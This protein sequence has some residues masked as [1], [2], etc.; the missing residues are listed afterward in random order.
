LDV[1][2]WLQALG[3]ERYA[4]AFRDAQITLEALAELTDADLRELGLPLG[5]R[6]VVLKAIR[7]LAGSPPS[8]AAKAE[9][10]K[11]GPEVI[12]IPSRAE[13]RQLTVMFVDLVGSTALAGRL[14]PEEMAELLHGYREAVA[15]EVRRFAGHVAKLMGDGVLAYFGWPRAH[16]D[17]A[18]RAVLAGL[19]VV[20][21]VAE[22]RAPSAEALAARVGIATGLVVVGELVGEAEARERSVVGD[23][24]NLAARLQ[25]MAE[26]GTVMVAE[27]TRRLLGEA[28]AYAEGG[29]VELK[30]YAQPVCTFRVLGPSEIAGRFESR[31][32]GAAA[33]LIGREQELAL[34]LD[35]WGRVTAGEGQVV[36]LAGEPGIGKS[37]LVLALREQVR[38]AGRPRLRYQC[39]PHHTSSALYPVI[40]QLERAAGFARGDDADA[41]Q[42]KLQ[43]IL[44][45]T[46]EALPRLADLLGI[47]TDTDPDALAM[48]PQERKRRTF[49]ALLAQLDDQA[50][51][52]V[53][54]VLE[55]AHWLDPTTEELFGFIVERAQA[56]PVLLVVTFR[57]EFK[58][59]WTGHS[60]VT[61]LT[62]SRLRR[63]E[64]ATLAWRTAG[65]PL[66]ETVLAEITAKTDGVPLFIEELTKAVVE[67]SLLRDTAEPYALAGPLPP[68]AVPA[69]LQDSLLARLDR[70]SAARE[71]AQIGAVIG[72]EFGYELLAAVAPFPPDRLAAA[73]EELTEAELVFRRDLPQGATY[74]FKHA[75]V[76]DAAYA[77][78][79]K[80]R[81]QQLHARVAQVV[82]ERFGEKVEIQ[83]QI[84]A[85]H[86]TEAGLPERA[87]DYWAR[88]GQLNIA[89]F[90]N[91]E[92]IGHLTKA[93]QALEA[94]PQS[95]DRDRKE[96][97]LRAALMV[98]LIAAH[99]YGSVELEECALRAVDVLNRLGDDDLRFTI[100]R[101]WWNSK[102]LRRPLPEVLT[103]SSELLDFAET[104]NDPVQR[105]AA[106]R[107]QGY[108]LTIT[109]RFIEAR[110][111]LAEGIKIADQVTDTERF[112]LYGEQP[113]MVCRIYSGLNFSF[114]GELDQA[115]IFLE[116]GISLAR[117]LNNP[118]ALAWALI[119][120]AQAACHWKNPAIVLKATKEALPICSTHGLPQWLALANFSIGWALTRSGDGSHGIP[121]MELGLNQWHASG[122][123]LHSSMLRG[124]LASACLATDNFAPARAHLEAALAHVQDHG[125][126][127][128]QAELVRINAALRL[129][130]GAE[131]A[132]AAALL[133]QAIQ[134][135]KRQNASLWRLRASCDLARLWAGQGERQKAHDLLAPVYGWFTEGFDTPDL[136]EAEEL[137]NGLR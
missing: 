58:P 97:R 22:L 101:A 72:R 68:L 108:S 46:A 137:L 71:V 63:E 62:L 27:R 110:D 132:D 91:A 43:H 32:G 85:Y 127:Y 114:L 106:H 48:T 87:I 42:V 123:A 24:P 107:A 49:E 121:Q 118:H 45:G 76:Q 113:G 47:G 28:F 21:R 10:A 6:K 84:V 14:D 37:R 135:A 50:T 94:L 104:T 65:K 74:V 124:L 66:P 5:P 80:S 102:L 25:Q 119:I 77:T 115:L 75:L 31:H 30:G 73:L 2:A 83:P 70:L 26:P 130:E 81:R 17:A 12:S 60:H 36:L 54:L 64:A 52:P 53:L 51:G 128:F 93:L 136:K 56:L 122:A 44:G 23:T 90:A 125:E 9:P 88:A 111:C 134:I 18:E 40:T 39:S 13:R 95:P 133:L 59:P 61:C 33:Q 38:A 117:H 109:G 86:L 57:P 98:P 100:Y 131:P 3:L 89:R 29:T 96:L 82:E 34:L 1:A 105:A 116:D 92:A 55:D 8:S 15:A 129:R 11:V 78:L 4:P 16:E 19:A 69:T 126:L 103:L 7:G 112:H 67:S 41:K 79:L 20:A 35:R 120:L 99:G